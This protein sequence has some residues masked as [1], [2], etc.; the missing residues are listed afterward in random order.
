[1]QRHGGRFREL[2]PAVHLLAAPSTHGIC[3]PAA[4]APSA[5]GTGPL[6]VLLNVLWCKS[7][8]MHLMQA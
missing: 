7:C 8:L 1:M 4:Y 3:F 6:V 2:A 5:K